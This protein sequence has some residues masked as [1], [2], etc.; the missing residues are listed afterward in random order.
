VLGPKACA[1]T[2]GFFPASVNPHLCVTTVATCSHTSPHTLAQFQSPRAA[3]NFEICPSL[4]VL[5]DLC[6]MNSLAGG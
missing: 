2:P 5:H 6:T 4:G 3:R 1:T